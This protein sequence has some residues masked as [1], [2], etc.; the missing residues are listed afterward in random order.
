MLIGCHLSSARG[1]AAMGRD[2]LSIDANTFQFFTRNPRGGGIK[3]FDATDAQ[4]LIDLTHAHAFGPLV[5]HAPYTLNACAAEARIRDFARLC[6]QE[7]LARLAFFP[8]CL[9]NFHPG[10]HVGQGTE[11]GIALTSALLNELITPDMPTTVLFE[12][13]SGQGSE[14]GATF[15]QLGELLARSNH[16][17]RMG[18][19]LD[20]CHVFA[21]GY[22]LKNDL[23]GVLTAFDKTVGLRYLKAV[24]LNDS[25]QPLGSHRDRHACIGCGEIGLDALKRIT[26]HPALE[27]LPFLLETPNE[28]PGYAAEIRLLRDLDAPT[29]NIG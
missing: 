21:A 26:R 20:T 25:M 9:Y 12:T 7:D 2:A 17:A 22:D 8:D 23:D 5:A 6:L 14:I 18:V 16:P 13:M 28:L 29:S 11:A 4:A 27:H 15:A 3:P 19:C 10:S 24:H 1:F